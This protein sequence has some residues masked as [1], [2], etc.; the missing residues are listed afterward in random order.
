MVQQT[1]RRSREP[2]SVYGCRVYGSWS[3]EC[4]CLWRGL[5][6]QGERSTSV[7]PV[8]EAEHRLLEDVPGGQEDVLSMF[9]PGVR[10]HRVSLLGGGPV[11]FPRGGGEDPATQRYPTPYHVRRPSP[12]VGKPTSFWSM[13]WSSSPVV[14]AIGLRMLR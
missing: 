4:R 6:N 13:Q 8:G 1:V 3:V 10:S 7:F 14:D 2:S 9:D 12:R 5:G 11:R